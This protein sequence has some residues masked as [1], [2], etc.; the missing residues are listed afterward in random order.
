[1]FE[2]ISGGSEVKGGRKRGQMYN[3]LMFYVTFSMNKNI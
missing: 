3:A 1:M 2:S